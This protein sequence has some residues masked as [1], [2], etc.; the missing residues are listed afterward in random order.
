MKIDLP[1]S[2]TDQRASDA[3]TACV[4]RIL[5]FNFH[6]IV[7][8]AHPVRGDV[9]RRGVHSDAAGL[10]IEVR[11]VPGTFDFLAANLPFGERATFVGSRHRSRRTRR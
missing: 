2:S 10:D 11:R 5:D 4:R 1:P 8:E 7:N 9:F 3:R 6:R